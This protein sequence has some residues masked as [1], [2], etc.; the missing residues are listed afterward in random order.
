MGKNWVD[1]VDYT[2]WITARIGREMA[3]LVSWCRKEK[4]SLNRRFLNIGVNFPCDFLDFS[5]NSVYFCEKS[6]FFCFFLPHGL[7]G[8]GKT[9]IMGLE[10]GVKYCHFGGSFF[11][12][13]IFKDFKVKDLR[14]LREPTGTKRT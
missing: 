1:Y 2:G 13:P 6:V 8:T 10:Y 7:K 14:N 4:T 3:E 12:P 9:G 11:S 5:C